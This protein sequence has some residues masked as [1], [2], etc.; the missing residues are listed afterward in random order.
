MAYPTYITEALVCGSKN[1]LGADR[2]F[3][4]LTRDA[5][6]VHAHAKSVREERSK[7]RYG[8]QD[9]SH[10]R[11]TLIRGKSGWRIAGTEP[12]SNFYASATTREARA[13]LR[14]IIVLV[15]RFMQGESV[16]QAAIFDDVV[17]VCAASGNYEPQKLEIIATLRILN[18]LGYI[19]PNPA[20]DRFL[21][22][23][24][25]FEIANSLTLEDERVCAQA[26]DTALHESQL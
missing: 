11:A 1:S 13:L 18:T 10:I 15:R 7:Q 17:R 19:P 5:G 24:F 12:I 6:M 2:F 22:E 4:L 16:Y 25:P 9:C 3:T 23:A 20:Y 8:L 26:I 21:V 14:N